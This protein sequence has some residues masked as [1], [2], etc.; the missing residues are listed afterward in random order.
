MERAL[1]EGYGGHRQREP[2]FTA[3]RHQPTLLVA[4]SSAA[5][6]HHGQSSRHQDV[7]EGGEQHTKAANTSALIEHD[8]LRRHPHATVG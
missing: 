7:A 6:V 5:N 2:A 1:G 8:R 3:P 4:T